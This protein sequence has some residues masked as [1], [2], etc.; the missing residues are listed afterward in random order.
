MQ[1][2]LLSNAFSRQNHVDKLGCRSTADR[3]NHASD[4]LMRPSYSRPQPAVL[5]LNGC[6][7]EQDAAA[8]QQHCFTMPR[9]L[10]P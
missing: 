5:S 9:L 6:R 8:P 1:L 3:T 7:D 2:P 10:Q 4:T